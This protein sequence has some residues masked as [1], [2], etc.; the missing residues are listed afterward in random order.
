MAA[1]DPA[2][3][4]SAVALLWQPV[5]QPCAD[6]QRSRGLRRAVRWQLAVQARQRG[7]AA[8]HAQCTAEVTSG[9]CGMTESLA[10]SQLHA[11]LVAGDDVHRERGAVPAL[12]YQHRA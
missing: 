10:A 7:V 11:A 9:S 12:P 5:P 8:G 2:R 3:R 1:M 6:G 4:G